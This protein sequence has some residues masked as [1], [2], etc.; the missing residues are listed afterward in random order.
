M[1]FNSL[2]FLFFYLPVVFF[3][4][5]LVA[6]ARWGGARLAAIWLGLGSLF[7]YG[8]W[9]TRFLWLLGGSIV[10]NYILGRAQARNPRRPFWLVALAVGGNLA[11]LC[12]FKYAGLFVSTLNQVA[13][14]GFAVPSIAL[15]LGISFYTFTQIAFQMDVYKGYAEEYD[16]SH[17]VLFVTY[18]PHL[19]AG[20]ILHHKQMMPQFRRE[21]TYRIDPANVAVGLSLFTAGLAKKVLLADRLGE[22][23]VALFSFAGQGGAPK[24]LSAWAGALAFTFQIYF[25]FS[26]YSDMAIGLSLL[27]NITLPI[28]FN[29]PY[30]AANIADFWRRW[31]ISLS[32]FL[33]DYLYIPLGGNRLGVA[34]RYANLM[35]VMLLGG[36]WHGAS[37]T[38]LLWG[39]LHGLYLCVNHLWGWLRGLLTRRTPGRGERL[40]GQ[41]LT[42]LAVVVAWVL[43]RAE[44]APAAARVLL[45]MSGQAGVSLPLSALRLYEWLTGVTAPAGL[46]FGGAFADNPALAGLGAARLA[47][48]LG[49]SA[50]VAWLL[51]N[52]QAVFREGL[53]LGG[54]EGVW[55]LNWRPNCGWAV[56]LGLT[57]AA[58]VMDMQHV[59]EFLYFQ[60]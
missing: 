52:T 24:L 59:S 35:V 37:W 27:F 17:Y 23:S 33:K 29:S 47:G 40:A 55:R 7:F 45:G 38:F 1:L 50:A 15:P 46:V 11:A 19:V 13:G 30:R 6:G 12:L 54:T 42:F 8:W 41:A 5:F 43:F 60:F 16:F 32:T 25:D 51:P 58:C 21:R 18:F 49:V 57:L 20:P 9:D 10:F 28:N 39:G 2:E 56:V 22:Y 44:S 4:F 31:H 3:G 26:G 34:R 36:L 53:H 14:T 48:L